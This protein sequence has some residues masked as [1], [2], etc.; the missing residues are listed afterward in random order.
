MIAPWNGKED[1]VGGGRI[2]S[3]YDMGRRLCGGKGEANVASV[4]A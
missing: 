3:Y 2:V 4:K 1:F